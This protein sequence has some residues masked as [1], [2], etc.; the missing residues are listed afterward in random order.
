MGF[1]ESSPQGI[2][3]SDLGLQFEVAIA[4]AAAERGAKALLAGGRVVVLPEVVD[5]TGGSCRRDRSQQRCECERREGDAAQVFD[6]VPPPRCGLREGAGS[7]FG[8]IS[9]S[10][11]NSRIN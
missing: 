5:T 6:P 2:R 8:P 11:A 4:V 3:A 7:S 9:M 10:N 1:V